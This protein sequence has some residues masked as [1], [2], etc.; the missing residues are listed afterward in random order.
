MKKLLC[1]LLSIFLLCSVLMPITV[2]AENGPYPPIEEGGESDEEF[3]I[4]A[5]IVMAMDLETE[6]V[7]MGSIYPAE[8]ELFPVPDIFKGATYDLAT[9]TLTLKNVKAPYGVITTMAMGDDFKIKLVGYNEI[10]SIISSGD[11]RGGS[12]TLVGDGELVVNKESV[13]YSG[14][15]IDA[16]DTA[17]FFRAEKDVDLKIHSFTEDGT[18]AIVIN[19]STILDPE[20]LI[21]LEGEVKQGGT[22]VTLPSKV[23]VYEQISAFDL[24]YDIVEAPDYV[25]KKDDV[26]CVGFDAVEYDEE[27]NEKVLGHYIFPTSY[28][29][30]L[31]CYATDIITDEEAYI[32]AD[33]AAAGYEL[34]APEAVP[35]AFRNIF[36]PAETTDY[37]L[38]LSED[39]LTKYA[40]DMYDYGDGEV[41]YEI[42]RVIEHEKYGNIIQL[43]TKTDMTGLVPQKTG[44]KNYLSAIAAGTIVMNDG[45]SVI[46]ATVKLVSAK[47]GDDGIVVR[48]TPLKNA[49]KYRIYR[50]A[51]GEKSWKTLDTVSGAN[52]S[53]FKDKTAKNGVK[54]T[55]TVKAFN[56]VGA[57]GYN[58]SGISVIRIATPKVT[59]T[60]TSTG[61]NVKWGK[62]AGAKSYN[63]YRKLDGVKDWT[64]IKKGFTGTSYTDKT[65]KAGK[66]YHYTVRAVNGSSASNFG[67]WKIVFLTMPKI[68]KPENTRDG[69]KISW[70]K[71]P[72]AKQYIVY[73]KN[74]KTGKWERAGVTS[75]TSFI[76]KVG[77]T[78]IDMTYTVK[79]QSGSTY[80]A[81]NKTGV[82]IHH[83][84]APAFTV[85][86]TAK[87]VQLKWSN[88]AD[89]TGFKIYRRVKGTSQWTALTSRSKAK[90]SKS[91]SVYYYN[92]TTV[93]S[94]V[95]YEYAMRSL[96]KKANSACDYQTVTFL[97]A[98]VLTSVKNTRSGVQISWKPVKGA[99]SYTL[100]RKLGKGSW[101]NIGWTTQTTT[102]DPY[103]QNGKTYTYTVR[104]VNGSSRSTYKSQLSIKVKLL[105]SVS[106]A[107]QEKYAEYA[108]NIRKGIGFNGVYTFSDVN[109]LTATQAAGAIISTK[110]IKYSAETMSDDY[111]YIYFHYPVSEISKYSKQ[112]FGKTFDFTKVTGDKIFYNAKDK[113][114]IVAIPNGVGS[115][116]DGEWRFSH[117]N[118][119]SYNNYTATLFYYD[120]NLETFEYENE[121][122]KA[123][124]VTMV[125]SEN[126][127][128]YIT[129]F[130]D[131]AV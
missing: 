23:D 121:P 89:A 129:G 6:E 58:K 30:E 40:F 66:I 120:Y 80:S 90:F 113:T 78:N 17:S 51:A 49:E 109:K 122:S 9:N 34:V 29:E 7:E 73:N 61:V 42:Y 47:N 99:K 106:N 18:T 118:E 71:V 131:V 44:E 22:P 110:A 36:V 126:G 48:W 95:T 79:A 82:K 83:I 62:V 64:V 130:K 26:L 54:Y 92:D 35:V 70:S 4:S 63:V 59:L 65:A 8:A 86:N 57:G 107:V 115:E 91:G 12:I 127:T 74:L 33:Y 53:S 24:D 119:T 43:T 14:I 21:V 77:S 15:E 46:P 85:N 105:A 3:N 10:G 76:D 112:L 103:A 11:N 125:F 102:E 67:D 100:Y 13:S 2:F 108:V 128:Y 50:K 98:P 114:I 84:K 37:D 94:G 124:K 20:Q 87:G 69:V 45:G 60:N 25:F 81:Y 93:K 28:D 19:E 56:K 111:N 27:Y 88:V 116:G 68:N 32:V 101:E 16:E 41:E 39:G 117:Y 123:C 55:Y 5:I 38:A 52:T 31:A 104:A 97:T 72:G 96:G 75:G 1:I